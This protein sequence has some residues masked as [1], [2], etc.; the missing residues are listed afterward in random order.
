M[1]F[2]HARRAG[3]YGVD[4]AFMQLQR[5]GWDIHALCG[6]PRPGTRSHP[7]RPRTLQHH[8]HP[9]AAGNTGH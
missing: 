2:R 6:T 5:H 3:S 8:G 9:P 4:A 7:A 1:G